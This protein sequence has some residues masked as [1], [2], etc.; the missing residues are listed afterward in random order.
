M[1]DAPTLSV[2]FA[3]S[4]H[5]IKKIVKYFK[6]GSR[7]HRCGVVKSHCSSGLHKNV[8]S[9][10]NHKRAGSVLGD[11]AVTP[12]FQERQRFLHAQSQPAA[13]PWVGRAVCRKVGRLSADAQSL[14]GNQHISL[15]KKHLCREVAQW[16]K[17]VLSLDAQHPS[18][19]C[20]N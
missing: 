5:L 16:G 9:T 18:N 13:E 15:C 1:G 10:G 7:E 3:Q 14:C 4:L 11:T 20:Q 2:S 8:L 19:L 12:R 6:L 17:G